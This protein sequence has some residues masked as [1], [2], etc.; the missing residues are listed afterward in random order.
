MAYG[1]VVAGDIQ[2]FFDPINHQQ[3]M[4]LVQRRV[5]D[6]R[7]LSLG[8]KFLR[9]EMMAQGNLR[10]SILG[11]PQGGIVSPLL[12]NIYLHALDR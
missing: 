7:I 5:R 1:W 4:R 2:S 9:A 6:K 11:T 12:A 3:L 10:H 8:W